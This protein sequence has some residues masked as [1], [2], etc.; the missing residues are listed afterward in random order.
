MTAPSPLR[1][2]LCTMG[3]ALAA[4]VA[5]LSGVFAGPAGAGAPPASLSDRIVLSETA[6]AT[7]GA[8]PTS[9]ARGEV[10]TAA[11]QKL[12][13]SAVSAGIPGVVWLVRTS[14]GTKVLTSGKADLTTGRDIAAED[15]FRVGSITKS[16]VATVVLQL[17]N[18]KRLRLDDGVA[19]KLPG[20]LP[21]GSTITV[22]QLLSHRSGLYN[23]TEDPAFYAA[24]EAAPSRRWR[25]RELI[26]RFGT[27]HPSY[28]APG[29]G[30]HYSNTNYLVLGL[31][32]ERVTGAEY[33]RVIERRILRP[34]GLSHTYLP[35]GMG[36]PGRNSHGYSRTAAGRW[37]DV[38]AV[39][40]PSIAGAAGE[41]VSTARDVDRFYRALL[42]GRLL[43][44]DLLAQMRTMR[45]IGSGFGY[46]LG[47]LSTTP[48]DCGTTGYGH[49]G[50]IPGFL[51]QSSQAADGRSGFTGLI[52]TDSIPEAAIPHL[53]AAA[54][55]SLC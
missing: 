49:T 31:L 45:P 16:F 26:A 50:G 12:L 47:L 41:M 10:D 14:S 2:R 37:E 35:D 44:R 34:V 28:F 52:N 36:L 13:D 42:T 3:V 53:T 29:R 40:H 11:L 32:I 22:R 18:E 21:A 25:P 1:R 6:R 5:L 9:G 48:P 38:T 24:V 19:K 51:S 39:V 43:P 7:A 54:R 8:T 23:Y 55:L 17:V 15:R 27:S 4:A 30:W 20:V 33:D 46:G